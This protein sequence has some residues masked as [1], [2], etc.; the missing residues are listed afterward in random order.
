VFV[1]R[2]EEGAARPWLALR[3]GEVVVEGCDFHSNMSFADWFLDSGPEPGPAAP[4]TFRSCR[5]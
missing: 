1:A 2:A 5:F 3:G 4:W